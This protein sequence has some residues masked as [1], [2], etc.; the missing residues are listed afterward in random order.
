MS[1]LQTDIMAFAALTASSNDT[2]SVSCKNGQCDV[3]NVANDVPESTATTQRSW[4]D[5]HYHSKLITISHFRRIQANW[6]NTYTIQRFTIE[7][8]SFGWTFATKNTYRQFLINPDTKEQD[9]SSQVH[10]ES[11]N[12]TDSSGPSRFEA[13]TIASPYDVTSFK[14][15]WGLN[16]APGA[17]VCQM[18][19][20]EIVLYGAQT[21]ASGGV[22]SG[23]S[24]GAADIGVS[25]GGL[26]A[27][28]IVGITL[29]VFV[30]AVGAVLLVTRQRN[31]VK[32]RRTRRLGENLVDS[33]GIF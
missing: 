13:C 4:L 21:S 27:G 28:A 31:L 32:R 30:A 26:S 19:I 11:T 17:T 25:S 20:E 18:N 16:K 29:A 8:A 6:N 24:S 7:Y 33:V 9:V 3:P 2:F 23:T 1:N 15:T 22:G 14:L 12:V 10:C 5:W